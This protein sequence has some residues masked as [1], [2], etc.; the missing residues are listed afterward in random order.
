MLTLAEMKKKL[1]EDPL[2][3]PHEEDPQEIWDL[4]DR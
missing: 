4:Y 2:W 1:T 3:Q